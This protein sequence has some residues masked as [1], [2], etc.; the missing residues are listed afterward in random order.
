MIILAIGESPSTESLP[1]EIELGEGKVIIVDPFTM[2]TSVPGVFAGG[3]CVS[4]PA[5][6]IQ[7]IVDGK[8]AVKYIEQFLEKSISELAVT[9][10]RKQV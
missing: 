9:Q 5:T 8:R 1:K 7:A 6:V 10:A 4:G 2:E 3:D